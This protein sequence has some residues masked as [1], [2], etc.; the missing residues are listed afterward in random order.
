MEVIKTE[1]EIV[2][3]NWSGDISWLTELLG[4]M[5]Y[6]GIRDQVSD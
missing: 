2:N 3:L 4:S 5:K 6:V 1:F